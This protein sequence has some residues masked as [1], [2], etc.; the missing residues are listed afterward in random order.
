MAQSEEMFVH[1]DLKREGE[2]ALNDSSIYDVS[3]Y[4][5]LN[6]NDPDPEFI[7]HAMWQIDQ[8][9][10]TIVRSSGTGLSKDVRKVS[11]KEY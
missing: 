4:G 1:G 8:P 11:K 3:S 10:W 5:W 7:G 6:E 2:V 9:H